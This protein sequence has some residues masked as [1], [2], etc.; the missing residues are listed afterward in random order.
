MKTEKDAALGPWHVEAIT[1]NGMPMFRV[2]NN[3]GLGIGDFARWDEATLAASAPELL[4]AARAVI[5]ESELFSGDEPA[6][7]K[8]C[9]TAR[10]KA[11][12]R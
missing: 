12:G 3:C 1:K 8:L 2:L 5:K 4:K 9:R 6:W 10:D 11:E 7:V